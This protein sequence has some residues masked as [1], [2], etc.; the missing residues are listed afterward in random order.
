MTKTG[1]VGSQRST[2]EVF[3]RK[4]AVYKGIDFN[5]IK[6]ISEEIVRGASSVIRTHLYAKGE[7]FMSLKRGL[8]TYRSIAYEKA[9]ELDTLRRKLHKR[10]PVLDLAANCWG[11]E[12]LVKE[13]LRRDRIRKEKPQATTGS[14]PQGHKSRASSS[15][16]RDKGCN[17]SV[18]D[19]GAEEDREEELDSD[20]NDGKARFKSRNRATREQPNEDRRP[21]RAGK[22]H[23]RSL[24][25]R[26]TTKKDGGD[27]APLLEEE[28]SYVE[29]DSEDRRP[30]RAV[31]D[32]ARSSLPR[33]TRDEDGREQTRLSEEEGSYVEEDSEDECPT[34]AGNRVGRSS[35]MQTGGVQSGNG[36]RKRRRPPSPMK[37]DNSGDEKNLLRA[38]K[39]NKKRA[40]QPQHAESDSG[41]GME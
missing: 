30:T 2:R 40:A 8:V 13:V 9:S 6:P 37:F 27:T 15:Q 17:Q 23:V 26:R 21:A 32:R 10:F 25:T 38:P 16:I 31:K 11:A 24:R 35:R 39:R 7:S 5:A 36:I 33:H 28:G 34:R 14:S 1:K 18:D 4:Y 3:N 19:G 22:S 29:E 12:W 41:S 20:R